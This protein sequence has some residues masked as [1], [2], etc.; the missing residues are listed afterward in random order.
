MTRS[1]LK[2]VFIFT[3][4]ACLV[5]AAVADTFTLT[6]VGSPAT[7]I[8]GVYTGP[9]VATINGAAGIPVICNDYDTHTHVG[10]SWT[11]TGTS[12]DQ[13]TGSALNTTVKFAMSNAAEQAKAYAA[14]AS[15]AIN[16]LDE[17]DRYLAGLYNYAIWGIFTPSALDNLNSTDREKAKGLMVDAWDNA[18]STAAYSNVMIWTP[19]APSELSDAQEFITVAEPTAMAILLFNL[20][21]VGL[22]LIFVRRRNASA[23]N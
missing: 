22:L 10:Q 4:L 16:M 1:A 6:G 2:Y 17:N 8:G 19:S 5:P 15:L 7:V 11:V 12:V 3:L 9:Y 20:L 21:A 13:I 14:A 18:G 23:L